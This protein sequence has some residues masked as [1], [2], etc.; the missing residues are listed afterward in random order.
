MS[1]YLCRN[2]VSF[3]SKKVIALKYFIDLESLKIQQPSV[4]FLSLCLKEL[5]K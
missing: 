1:E 3:N 2:I 4:K 5:Y